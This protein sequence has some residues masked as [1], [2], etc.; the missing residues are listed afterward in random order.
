MVEP[1]YTGNA[2]YYHLSGDVTACGTTHS[3]QEFVC[4]LN[5]HQFDPKT[6]FGNPNN[7]TLCGRKVR[8][9]GPNGTAEV[10]IVDRLPSG[11]YG[12][13]DLSPAAFDCIVGNRNI[14]RAQVTWKFV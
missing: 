8:V 12:D 5:S 7:N 4:A 14:G 11:Q 10:T 1:I 2:T 3:D 9:T 6:P 13:L